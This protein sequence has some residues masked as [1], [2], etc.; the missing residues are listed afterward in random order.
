MAKETSTVVVSQN[1]GDPVAMTSNALGVFRGIAEATRKTGGSAAANSV[2]LF[3]A[4][5]SHQS[6]PAGLPQQ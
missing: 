3:G 1:V 2:G 6:A 5:V 4:P